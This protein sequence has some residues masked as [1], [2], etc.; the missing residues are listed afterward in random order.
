MGLVIAIPSPQG[1]VAIVTEQG[2]QPRVFHMTIAEHD[3]SLSLMPSI[4][5]ERA[6]HQVRSTSSPP[7]AK[8]RITN[9][10]AVSYESISDG[11]HV[12]RAGDLRLPDGLV[13]L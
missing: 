3:L 2:L 11:H 1:A 7:K 6:A 5:P 8:S 12:G 13:Y 10:S 4:R 9:D